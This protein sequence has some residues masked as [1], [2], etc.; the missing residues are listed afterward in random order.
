VSYRFAVRQGTDPED[1]EIMMSRKAADD[2]PFSALAFK[3]MTDQFVGTLT[4]IR[5]YR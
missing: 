5:V 1:A 4:F 3:I 2:E